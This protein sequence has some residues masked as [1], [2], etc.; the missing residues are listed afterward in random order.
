MPT[1]PSCY[2]CI[3]SLLQRAWVCGK[4]LMLM[5]GLTGLC[6]LQ[7][8]KSSL[9]LTLPL[10]SENLDPEG[11]FLLETGEDAFLYAGKAVSSELLH[12][13]FEVRSVNEVIP[14]QFLLQ[15]YDNEP[16]ILLNKMV[17]EIR[18][19]RCSYLRDDVP[20]LKS[21]LGSPYVEFLV[22]VHRQI[23]HSICKNY[24]L[25][26][27]F[28][29]RRC[30]TLMFFTTMKA[31]IPKTSDFAPDTVEGL[32]PYPQGLTFY[33]STSKKSASHPEL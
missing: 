21:G 13:L 18:R 29:S 5:K 10:S 3:H 32:H 16:S 19:Q 2:C 25:A 27:P 24:V 23:Q 7:L 8:D 20:L 26:N 14:G 22:Y 11:I 15:E 28:Y 30:K 6:K 4:M 9:P 17:N 31:Q 12:Q 1:S 33:F